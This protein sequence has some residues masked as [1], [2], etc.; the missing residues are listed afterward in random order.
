MVTLQG[1]F[2]D[3]VATSEALLQ[4]PVTHEVEPT[5]TWMVQPLARN[6]NQGALPHGRQRSSMFEICSS[7]SLITPCGWTSWWGWSCN[8]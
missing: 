1:V 2:L 5:V 6:Q 7:G 8:G 3:N 4:L